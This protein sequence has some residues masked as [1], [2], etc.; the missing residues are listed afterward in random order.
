MVLVTV[1]ATSFAM[2]WS[3]F[4]LCLR[5]PRF[6]IA[7]HVKH[8][9]SIVAK[10]RQETKWQY[11]FVSIC[12]TGFG[13]FGGVFGGG[14]A[15]ATGQDCQSKSACAAMKSGAFWHYRYSFL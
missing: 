5:A 3:S 15:M 12:V 9:F 8:Y 2:F 13:Q 10:I 4:P 6:A 1:R 11:F 14:L 7:Q